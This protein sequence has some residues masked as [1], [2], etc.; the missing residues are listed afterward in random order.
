MS[1]SPFDFNECGLLINVI[2]L[3]APDSWQGGRYVVVVV[4]DGD[5]HIGLFDVFH[6][7]SRSGSIAS[8]H[9]G[10][11]PDREDSASQLFVGFDDANPILM[12]GGQPA[13]DRCVRHLR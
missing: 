10:A 12:L 3:R 4:G 8:K 7:Q 9:N 1:I 5:E 6:Q 2:T 13:Q 11:H